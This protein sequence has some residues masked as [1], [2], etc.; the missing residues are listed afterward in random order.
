MATRKRRPNFYVWT[1]LGFPGVPKLAPGLG[2]A[3][4]R[5]SHAFRWILS[6]RPP[7]VLIRPYRH[8]A[9]GGQI[10]RKGLFKVTHAQN[11]R[12]VL[13]KERRAAHAQKLRKVLLKSAEKG[14]NG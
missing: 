13:L 4:N 5:L 7:K 6:T 14:L 10:V 2:Q 8:H 3:L 9:V 1:I 12:Q 11:P